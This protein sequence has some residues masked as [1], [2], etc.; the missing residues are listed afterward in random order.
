MMP[1]S[2]SV[3][4]SQT[5]QLHY[6]EEMTHDPRDFTY[7]TCSFKF[8]NDVQGDVVRRKENRVALC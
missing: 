3:E 8:V 7:F 2:G 6:S 5:Q 4:L 1:V